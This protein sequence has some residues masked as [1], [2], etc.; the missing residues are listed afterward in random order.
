MIFKDEHGKEYE[1][2]A[3]TINV[4]WRISVYGVVRNESGQAL[5]IKSHNN[6]QWQF[7]GGGV[8]IDEPVDEA[9]KREFLE[10]VGYKIEVHN[11]K[12]LHVNE[13]NFYGGGDRYFHSLQLFFEVTLADDK[14]Y[15]EFIE[16]G[17]DMDYGDIEWKKIE[18]LEEKD[19]Q[20][21][22]VPIVTL[23]TDRIPDKP[24]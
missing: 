1:V 16:T 11:K 24:E 15:E 10:E 17:E 3:A 12:L 5:M 14:Q 4:A 13:Q 9:L 20:H 22:H 8:D 6:M 23:L 7:P 21:T 18:S 19:I 2:D